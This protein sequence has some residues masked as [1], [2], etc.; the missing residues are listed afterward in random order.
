VGS[1]MC[2]RDRENVRHRRVEHA[3][4]TVA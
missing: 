2:I 4:R 3:L 1:E